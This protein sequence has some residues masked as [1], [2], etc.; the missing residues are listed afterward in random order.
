MK[1]SNFL[2]LSAPQKPEDVGRISRLVN[3]RVAEIF[4]FLALLSTGMFVFWLPLGVL[5]VPEP[6]IPFDL[7]LPAF[8]IGS[9]VVGLVTALTFLKMC[10]TAR[11]Y[12]PLTNSDRVLEKMTN[13]RVKSY[14]AQ[15]TASGRL[16]LMADF[17]NVQEL[18]DHD[19]S[20]KLA[21][22]AQ[23]KARKATHS[24]AAHSQAVN[25]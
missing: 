13:D 12:T 20:C 24:I 6:K 2:L 4:F 8:Q 3:P 9:G 18:S 15:V 21:E 10:R 5:I 7:P 17:F 1:T 11:S 23:S 16:F 14:C 25:T 19:R 22:Q